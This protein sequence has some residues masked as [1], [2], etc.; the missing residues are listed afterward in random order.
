MMTTSVNI[1]MSLA[2]SDAGG[3]ELG[4]SEANLGGEFG[5]AILW[6]AV[7]VVVAGMLTVTMRAKVISLWH[8]EKDKVVMK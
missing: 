5:G 7:L 8:V 1:D 2:I 3:A 6:M 4:Q